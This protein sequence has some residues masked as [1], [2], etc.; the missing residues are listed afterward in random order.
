MAWNKMDLILP[1]MPTHEPV[2]APFLSKAQALRDSGKLINVSICHGFFASDIYEQGA[3]VV[4][5]ADGEMCLA[6]R[7]ADELAEEMYAARKKLKRK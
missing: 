3:A 5:V 2:F 6:Q 4:A 1:Y 7:V